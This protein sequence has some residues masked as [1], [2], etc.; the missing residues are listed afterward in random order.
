M[1][2]FKIFGISILVIIAIVFF[3]L[4]VNSNNRQSNTPYQ[5]YYSTQNVHHYRKQKQ[6]WVHVYPEDER[7]KD[8]EIQRKLRFKAG[9]SD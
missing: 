1:N 5:N 2:K 7:A 3:V 6:K 8:A 9:V 4:N